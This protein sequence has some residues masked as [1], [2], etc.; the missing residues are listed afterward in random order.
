M[1]VSIFLKDESH[2]AHGRDPSADR[3]GHP[4][5]GVEVGAGVPALPDWI[6][7]RRSRRAL[8][9]I[10]DEQLGQRLLGESTIRLCIPT[11]STKHDGEICVYKTPRHPDYRRDWRETMA[12][13][14]KATSAA[15]TYLAPYRTTVN[16]FIDGGLWANNPILVAVV[17]ALS[18]F[19][20]D[21]RQIRVLSLGCGETTF[22]IGRLQRMLG[23][24]CVWAS[25]AVEA[26]MHYQSRADLGRSMLLLGADRITRVSPPS[27]MIRVDLD[28][29]HSAKTYL[30]DVS[31]RLLGHED[32]EEKIVRSF[33]D[34]ERERFAPIYG[35]LALG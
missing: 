15:P 30:P 10:L 16:E 24:L 1:S 34:G 8:D 21:P 17:E 6:W 3:R 14:A 19:E 23:G 13:V 4:A 26:A 7:T 11:A 33:L 18:A 32:T 20:L 29:W 31:R 27:S 12:D 5:A 22:T 25:K 35:P 28:D 2:G 9:R